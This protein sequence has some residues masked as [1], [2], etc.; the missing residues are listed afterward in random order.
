MG[1][2]HDG[3]CEVVTMVGSE[4]IGEPSFRSLTSSMCWYGVTR[5]CASS[6]ASLVIACDGRPEA[7]L[8]DQVFGE[9]SLRSH[10]SARQGDGGRHLNPVDRLRGSRSRLHG[11]VAITNSARL[12]R[13][14][15]A[16][17]SP[18]AGTGRERSGSL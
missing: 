18:K 3:D 11:P 9:N 5:L 6:I 4:V 10:Q 14:V 15:E 7:N 2:D 17:S 12:D 13:Q 8:G 1:H 16:A